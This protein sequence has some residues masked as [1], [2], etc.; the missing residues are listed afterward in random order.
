MNHSVSC[1]LRDE[2][3]CWGWFGIC[4]RTSITNKNGAIKWS[5]RTHGGERKCFH[6][7]FKIQ[8]SVF[9][10]K[11]WTDKMSKVRFL[12]QVPATEDLF[13]KKCLF[14]H[15]QKDL[16]QF[17]L[18]SDSS[19][20]LIFLPFWI[21]TSLHFPLWLTDNENYLQLTHTDTDIISLLSHAWGGAFTVK[22]HTDLDA[23][24]QTEW[25]WSVV[26]VKGHDRGWVHLNRHSEE[27]CWH[28]YVQ[29]R[30]QP[31]N[32]QTAT[33]SLLDSC[34]TELN[35]LTFWRH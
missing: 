23:A 32:M 25:A 27:T 33:L 14:Q 7:L 9:N 15:D 12:G 1:G 35:F 11:I 3:D 19:W 16:T 2:G 22:E 5:E 13:L 20:H 30:V 29:M 21:V 31:L 17:L 26:Q 6:V 34:W 18:N 10:V 24:N 8:P 4:C 28:L